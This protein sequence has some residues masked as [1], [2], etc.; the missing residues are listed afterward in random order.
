M[1]KKKEKS[2]NSM[3]SDRSFKDILEKFCKHCNLKLI[4]EAFNNRCVVDIRGIGGQPAWLSL[5]QSFD[6][7]VD[8]KPKMVLRFSFFGENGLSAEETACK[9]ALLSIFESS[10]IV[11]RMSSGILKW[12]DISNIKTVERLEILCDLEA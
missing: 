5:D 9:F 7:L 6:T 3:K 2:I 10:S 8:Y 11:Y 12:I 1:S 4:I